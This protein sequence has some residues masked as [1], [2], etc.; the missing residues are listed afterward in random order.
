MGIRYNQNQICLHRRGFHKDLWTLPANKHLVRRKALACSFITHSRPAR[1]GPLL[2]FHQWG[3][4][5]SEAEQPSKVTTRKWHVCLTSEPV[6]MNGHPSLGLFRGMEWESER[7]GRE[8]YTNRDPATWVETLRGRKMDPSPSSAMFWT[9]FLL[10]GPW[11][12]G[13]KLNPSPTPRKTALLVP[14]PVI[15]VFSSSY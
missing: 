9:C 13:P 14:V 3:N 7:K 12:P 4:H 10:F 8:W 6:F 11:L 5:D 2:L 15:L 1:L